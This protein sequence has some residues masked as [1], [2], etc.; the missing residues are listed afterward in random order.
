MESLIK[1]IHADALALGACDKIKGNEDLDGII[2]VLFSPQGREFCIK[3]QFPSKSVFRKFIKYNPE[4][5]GVYID[6]GKIQLVEPENVFLIGNTRATIRV[7]KTESHKICLMHG[8]HADI[9]AGG[10][11]VVK[12]EK[13]KDSTA[14]IHQA[15][16]AV[17]L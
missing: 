12:V 9:H 5:H 4:K 2:K 17:V 8:A 14:E 1:Q 16:R 6:A 15:G 10:F 3:H 13:D 7:S 11:S